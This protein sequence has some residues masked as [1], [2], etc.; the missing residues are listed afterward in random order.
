M[1]DTISNAE[2]ILTNT[3]Y[4]RMLIYAVLLGDNS[5]QKFIHFPGLKMC[6]WIFSDKKTTASVCVLFI[7]RIDRK[8]SYKITSAVSAFWTL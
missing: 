5:Y 8:H 6:W 4:S 1:K 2:N 3:K 7:H